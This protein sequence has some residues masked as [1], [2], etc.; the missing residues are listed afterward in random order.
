M[1]MAVLARFSLSPSLKGFL[2]NSLSLPFSL[3]IG[4]YSAE[5]K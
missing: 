4:L 1:A 2:Y 3:Y 5:S